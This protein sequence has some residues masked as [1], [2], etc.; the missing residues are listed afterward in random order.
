[1]RPATHLDTRQRELVRSQIELSQ[2][3]HKLNAT[4]D[5]NEIAELIYAH[6]RRNFAAE[7]TWLFLVDPRFRQVRYQ[8]NRRLEKNQPEIHAWLA[9][10]PIPLNP[11]AG[12]VYMAITK[13]RN[14]YFPDIPRN[15]KRIRS[16]M[17]PLDLAFMERMRLTNVLYA[18]LILDREVVGLL[19]M[20]A[21]IEH[22]PVSR[23]ARRDRFR[24]LRLFC[25]QAAAALHRGRN[26]EKQTED[27]KRL[28]TIGTLAAGLVHDLKNPLSAITSYAEMA[29][30]ETNLDTRRQY[31]HSLTREAERLAYMI[32]DIQDFARGAPVIE[33]E[34]HA[35]G[36]V[37]DDLLEPVRDEMEIMGM[38]LERDL[39]F[40]GEVMIDPGQIRRALDNLLTNA[41]EAMNSRASGIPTATVRTE[42]AGDRYRILISDT[43]PG[44]PAQ[45]RNTLFDPLV[46]SGKKGGTGM[47]LWNVKKI[48]EAHQGQIMIESTTGGG[49]TFILDLPV[50]FDR[51]QGPPD[52]RLADERR[53]GTAGRRRTDPE[54]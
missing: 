31:L 10:G 26:A 33:A 17:R 22:L 37:M 19:G 34:M 4:S 41:R 7:M 38:R 21:R 8:S 24:H 48:V 54:A 23:E 29:E 51:R 5:L 47:G 27:Q 53:M 40:R 12:A 13:K 46:T 9:A 45:I 49:T 2:V 6:A 16:A 25:E 18:P 42:I 28:A 1:M 50:R 36:P 52:R 20:T 30:D 44:I 35:L 15:M 11:D 3:A 39:E 32:H 14:L 43:G